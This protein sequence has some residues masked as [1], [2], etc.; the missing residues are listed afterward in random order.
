M[1]TFS[2]IN[3]M[4]LQTEDEVRDKAKDVLG[5]NH[6]ENDVRQGTGQIA[7]FN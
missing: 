7:T 3:N 4:K 1:I 2:P 6:S 5:F